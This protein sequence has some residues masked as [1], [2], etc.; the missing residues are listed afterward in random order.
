MGW[1][2]GSYF[3]CDVWSGVSSGSFYGRVEFGSRFGVDLEEVF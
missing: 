3:I 1:I 2:K